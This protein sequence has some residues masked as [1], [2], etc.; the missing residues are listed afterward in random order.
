MRLPAAG[1]RPPHGRVLRST[2]TKAGA[3][4][5]Q[6]QGRVLTQRLVHR[7]FT[8]DTTPDTGPCPAGPVPRKPQCE[9]GRPQLPA[10]PVE[11]TARALGLDGRRRERFERAAHD[12][13]DLGADDVVFGS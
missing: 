6:Q 4:L 10:T 8:I 2:L 1:V 5:R 9:A 3:F 12:D 11:G 7:S 13:D